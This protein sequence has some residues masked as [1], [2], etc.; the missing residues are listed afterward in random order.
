MNAIAPNAYCISNDDG[1]ILSG[2]FATLAAAALALHNTTRHP[3]YGVPQIVACWAY[4][5]LA[6]RMTEVLPRGNMAINYGPDST[7]PSR[8][9]QF[10]A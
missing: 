5:D 6:G 2:P 4:V 8:A 9:A 1:D 7:D 10:P 3:R